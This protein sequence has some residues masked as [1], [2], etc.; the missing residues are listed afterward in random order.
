[1]TRDDVSQA[2]DEARR[3]AAAARADLREL[4]DPRDMRALAHPIR[5]ALL[6][7]LTLHGPLTATEAGEYVGQSASACSF[8]L[9]S[10]ARHGF[11]EET[12]EGKG[13]QRP[14]RRI[15][16]GTMM[17]APYDDAKTT[18]AARALGDMFIDRYLNRLQQARAKLDELP[19]QWADKQADVESIMWVTPAELEEINE[20]VVALALKH[21]ARIA[22]P[23]LRPDGSE[24]IELLYFTFNANLVSLVSQ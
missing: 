13:R 21:R 16:M 4:R 14:W 18:I 19:P 24:P 17:E 8:H 7:A 5:L 23:S 12:G 22:D 9:R 3:A 10:L 11:V 20:A 6:E 1:M 2:G 15:A